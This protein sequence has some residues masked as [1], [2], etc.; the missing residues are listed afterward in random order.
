LGRI[1]GSSGDRMGI[2]EN[3]ILGLSGRNRRRREDLKVFAF[4]RAESRDDW[5]EEEEEIG[6]KITG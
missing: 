6:R 1:S 5:F 3:R 4:Q 2:A